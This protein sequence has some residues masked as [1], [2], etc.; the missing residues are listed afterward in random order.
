MRKALSKQEMASAS[1][2]QRGEFQ[3]LQLN[4]TVAEIV[5]SIVN[6]SCLLGRS[7][8]GGS[9]GGGGGGG[10]GG[11]DNFNRGSNFSGRGKLTDKS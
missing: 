7:S 9:R 3:F 5:N 10:F 2:S 4:K 8:F 11:S 1:S 6:F